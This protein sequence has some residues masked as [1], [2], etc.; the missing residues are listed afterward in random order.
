[1]GCAGVA[2][3]RWV[4]VPAHLRHLPKVP[5]M[6]LLLSYLSG[7]V[8]E[9]RVKRIIIPF[10]QKAGTDVVLVFCL[11]EW[12]VHI[13]EANAAKRIMEQRGLR[14]QE[15]PAEMLLWRLTGRQNVFTAEGEMWKRHAKIMHEA[16]HRTIP[17]EQFAA[18]SRKT[19]ALIGDGGRVQ[20]NDYTHRFSLDAVGTTVIG[21]DFEALDKPHGAFVERYHEVMAAISSP[22]Y[23]FLP[24][25]ERWMPRPAIRDM[26]DSLVEEFR[27]LLQKKRDHPGP[28]MITYMLE[29]P[30]MSETE[31]RDN[32]IVTFMGGH[33]TTAGS[34]ST[35]VFLLGQY[36][37]VQARLRAEVASIMGSDE[38]RL[39][40]FSRMP[41]L[42]AVIRES[43]RFNNP[44]NVLIPRLSD[45]PLQVG[46]HVIPPDTPFIINM[47]AI[48]HN[49]T[50]WADPDAFDPD[51]FLNSDKST[52][53]AS[54][55]PFGLGPRQCPARA[56][57]LYEQK[58]LVSML[59]REYRWWIPKDTVH[60]DYIKNAF[61]PF[62][63][64]LPYDVDID[65][66]K[67][68]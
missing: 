48:L 21:Y 65:I 1:M 9:R 2:V 54:W 57:S 59:L 41:Y 68:T 38:P 10:A 19:F 62:A 6:P 56:F 33:D 32:I 25:L 7:E 20:W 4:R 66:V 37:D 16:L 64:S 30:E 50:S 52:A 14:K 28:D 27:V 36:Q 43:M 46:A 63:L 18:L 26:V 44:S 42:N 8:E 12:V 13:V 39:E 3:Y 17:I 29:N 22:A 40:H 5:V 47:C 34:L 11:G 58:V 60:H 23:I 53:D 31:L 24:A 49:S 45:D 61:S 15:L 67:L 35:I 51:R 55:I